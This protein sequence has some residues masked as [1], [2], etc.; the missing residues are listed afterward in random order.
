MVRDR[1]DVSV[2]VEELDGGVQV[3]V[4]LGR[5]IAGRCRLGR[6]GIGRD[7]G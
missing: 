3:S 2:D 1:G 6:P 4:L 5:R 7:R